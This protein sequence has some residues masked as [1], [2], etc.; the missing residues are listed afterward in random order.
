V[1]KTCCVFYNVKSVS[2]GGALLLVMLHLLDKRASHF[3]L[4]YNNV[5]LLVCWNSCNS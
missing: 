5:A 2:V 4:D 3:K 1:R